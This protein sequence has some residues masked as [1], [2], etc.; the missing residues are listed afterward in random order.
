MVHALYQ[1]VRQSPQWY[2]ELKLFF[3]RQSFAFLSVSQLDELLAIFDIIFQVPPRKHPLVNCYNPVKCSLLV[4][5][6]C[7]K[8][9]QKN[10]YSLQRR[11]DKIMRYLVESLEKY[12]G[13]QGNI[14]HLYR[15][16][17]EPVLHPR[18]QQ[19]SMDLMLMMKMDRIIQNKVVEEVLNLVYDGKF[20]IDSNALYLSSL[21]VFISQMD[22]FS[23]KSCW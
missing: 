13:E 23:A 15:L 5:E 3:L 18:D 21:W 14:G 7:W 22:T 19:D 9:Q 4:Y 16:M 20:S 11:C 10:I 8:V 6:T 17:R 1:S 2:F 12:F